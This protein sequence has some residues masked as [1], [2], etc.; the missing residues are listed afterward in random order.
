MP[1]MSR[2]EAILCRSAPWRAFAGRIVLPWML[3]DSEIT[4][5]VLE[6]GGG[7]GAMAAVLLGREPGID[8]TLT[9]VDPAMVDAATRRLSATTASV[10]LADGTSLPFVDE[11]FDTVVSFLMLHHVVDW[12]GV[13]AEANRVLR[14]GGAI[15]GYDLTRTTVARW[16]HRLD[17][18]VV[19]LLTADELAT[20]LEEIGFASVDV[21]AARGNHWMRFRGTKLDTDADGG[22]ELIRELQRS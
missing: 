1:V 6:I 7:S 9:D 22:P 8:L 2:A 19:E 4:G 20:G 17:R 10:E 3:S 11:S 13:L 5:R 16:F 14:P 12:H 18:S 15:I 21:E